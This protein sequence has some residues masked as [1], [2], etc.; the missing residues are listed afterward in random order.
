[1]K[2]SRRHRRRSSAVSKRSYGSGSLFVYKSKNGNESWYGSWRVGSSRVQRKIQVSF[3][4]DPAVLDHLAA[5][6]QPGPAMVERRSHLEASLAISV[7]EL[8]PLSATGV[9]DLPQSAPALA[10]FEQTPETHD[11]PDISLRDWLETFAPLVRNRVFIAA[12]RMLV[13]VVTLVE[14]EADIESPGHIL[15]II[16]VLLSMA[17]LCCTRNE[18]P[19]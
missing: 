7:E 8:F 1:M 18:K 6:I 9:E 12:M 15:L 14:A 11:S 2:T 5:P 4:S 19:D 13:M 3:Q 10:D 16:S 17:D